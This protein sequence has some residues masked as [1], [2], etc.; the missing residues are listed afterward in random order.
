MEETDSGCGDCLI[1][2]HQ[3]DMMSSVEAS[4]DTVDDVNMITSAGFSLLGT[5]GGSDVDVISKYVTTDCNE[6]SNRKDIMSTS[7]L[8]KEAEFVTVNH[9]RKTAKTPKVTT[10]GGTGGNFGK[11]RAQ[12]NIGS[13]KKNTK[14][15]RNRPVSSGVVDLLKVL[16]LT[17]HVYGGS[18]TG[19]SNFGEGASSNYA[20]SSVRSCSPVESDSTNAV[21]TPRHQIDCTAS[22]NSI[23]PLNEGIVFKY[24]DVQTSFDG[25]SNV[26]SHQR[27]TETIFVSDDRLI[28]DGI[29]EKSDDSRLIVERFDVRLACIEDVAVHSQGVS[30]SRLRTN[31][32][33]AAPALEASRLV[34][35]TIAEPT[36]IDNAAVEFAKRK[37]EL[38]NSLRL[39]SGNLERDHAVDVARVVNDCGSSVSEVS[40]ADISFGSVD[41]PAFT[42]KGPAV[43]STLYAHHRVRKTKRSELN[44]R[45]LSDD[46][47]CMTPVS[48]LNSV[49]ILPRDL[50]IRFGFDWD[51]RHILSSRT[52]GV[53][54]SSLSR[55]CNQRLAPESDE[56]N[57]E[58]CFNGTKYFKRTVK[59]NLGRR[60]R[61]FV[62]PRYTRSYNAGTY[63]QSDASYNVN[64]LQSALADSNSSIPT[65]A[66]HDVRTNDV[67]AGVEKCPTHSWGSLRTA[68]TYFR[69]GT[70]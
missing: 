52:D 44:S 43:I 39:K 68:Q 25:N 67:Y 9:R 13:N 51:V 49:S 64:T 62:T 66:T 50:T 58:Q 59:S 23:I 4:L 69:T 21:D 22:L 19:S 34:S 10:N 5:V 15:E 40:V 41:F 42:K 61:V 65:T 6:S 11:S 20:S 17:L 36:C 30:K 24:L 18:S 38:C 12:M 55:H 37:S 1:A 31:H 26:P 32:K 29:T 28:A 63:A 60:N 47:N 16:P 27:S 48:F 45:H 8:G 7:F 53:R 35:Q 33:S 54:A 3:K 56:T 70:S 57:L 2:E 46:L 14:M